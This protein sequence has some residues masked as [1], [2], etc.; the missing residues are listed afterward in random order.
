MLRADVSNLQEPLKV[1]GPVHE[2]LEILDATSLGDM[3][4]QALKALAQRAHVFVRVSPSH[5]LMIVQGG[6]LC[7]GSSVHHK[8]L[9]TF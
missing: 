3:D 4:T 7:Q 6:N 5:K 9:T 8:L 2:T 1:C